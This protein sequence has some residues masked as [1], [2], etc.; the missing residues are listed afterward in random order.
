MRKFLILI[1]TVILIILAYFVVTDGISI[2][3]FRI[4]SWNDLVNNNNNLDK[5]IENLEKLSSVTFPQEQTKLN[6]SYKQLKIKKDEYADLVLYSSETE[7]AAAT[8]T[9]IYETEFLWTKLGNYA[10]KNNGIDMKIDVVKGSSGQKNQYNLNFTLIGEY[11][12]ISDFISSVEND[13]KLG[14][15]IDKFLLVPATAQTTSNNN[16]GETESSTNTNLLQAT[17]TVENVGINIDIENSTNNNKT[18]TD[19]TNN[20]NTVNNN[21]VSNNT[22]TINNANTVNNT[23]QKQ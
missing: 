7:I 1:L 15:K 23:T 20:Q 11:A 5:D 3:N 17:F 10:T 2:G 22:N 16:S 8:Q 21:T 9:E 14:F 13:A 18:S 12:Y 6:D 4:L 19:T